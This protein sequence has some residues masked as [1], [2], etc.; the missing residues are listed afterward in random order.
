MTSGL[1]HL[2][3]AGWY[4][5]CQVQVPGGARRPPQRPVLPTSYAIRLR[6]KLLAE[7][8]KSNGAHV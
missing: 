3:D 7:M 5:S 2:S 1:P 4:Q 8:G 6:R